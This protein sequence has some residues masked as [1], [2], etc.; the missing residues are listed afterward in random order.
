MSMDVIIISDPETKKPIAVI[1]NV[2]P[3]EDWEVI[4]GAWDGH[5]F[6]E[7]VPLYED[8]GEFLKVMAGKGKRR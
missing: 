7:A 6:S 4:D 3:E 2:G 5:E 8:P 1:K